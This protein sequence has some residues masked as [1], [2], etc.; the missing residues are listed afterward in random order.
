MHI[1]FITDNFYPEVNAPA[2]RTFEHSKVWV[3]Q[4]NK[5]TIITCAPNFPEGK[6][7]DGYKN[8]LIYKEN[9][10]GINVWR[11]KTF[12]S[13][14]E[15][16]IMRTL[17][18]ISFMISSFFF[19]MF[20]RKPDVIIGTSPQFFTVISAYLI[21]I[22]K[23]AP[24]VFELRD[25]WPAS[26]TAVGALKHNW[27]ISILEKIELFLYKKAR[28]IIS[29]TKSFKTE[30]IKRGVDESKIK[31]IFNGS[32]KHESKQ[33]N[34]PNI[35]NDYDLKNQFV[36]G[37]IGT[38]GMAHALENV[39]ES[40]EILKNN[41]NIR[42]L[43]V[44]GGAEYSNLYNL[45]KEKNL[46]NLI[47][48]PSQPKEMIPSI[49]NACDIS[50]IHLRDAELFK[51]V[52]PSKIFESMVHGIPVLS[53][54]PFGEA[55]NIIKKYNIGICISPENPKKL[56]ETILELINKKE[57]LNLFSKNSLKASSEFDRNKLA[58]SMLE[59]IKEIIN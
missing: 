22:F 42:F 20:V 47:M 35:F 30:L 54:M 38:H 31:V 19:G 25:I 17:D 11:V 5:V 43:L 49:L 3:A 33:L 48:I 13:A 16:F 39:I 27:I 40:A 18:F 52:I 50:L 26:I 1:L 9:I 44:G 24:F 37:Y 21:S 10:Y 46:Q 15:G 12:I 8:K 34:I 28:L 4:G 32:D 29:V 58:I 7:F 56:A 2:T 55:T 6:V 23:R 45:S 59:N 41:K 57:L 14:N 51:T 53:A 36:V